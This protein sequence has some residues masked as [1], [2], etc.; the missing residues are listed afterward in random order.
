MGGWGAVCI[1]RTTFPE[2]PEAVS[3]KATRADSM[4]G[5]ERGMRRFISPT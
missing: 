3:T 4:A 5:K 2:R 1:A